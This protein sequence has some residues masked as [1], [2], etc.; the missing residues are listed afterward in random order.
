MGGI[1]RIKK[2]TETLVFVMGNEN[3]VSLSLSL[4]H[5][6]LTGIPH[7]F[8]FCLFP[9]PLNFSSFLQSQIAT[10]GRWYMWPS[11]SEQHQWSSSWGWALSV[12]VSA[13]ALDKWEKRDTPSTTVSERQICWAYLRHD[14]FLNLAE[15][16]QGGRGVAP[17][18]HHRS[19]AVTSLGVTSDKFCDKPETS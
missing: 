9:S 14:S 11:T 10:V 4:S 1:G 7:R 2:K 19:R 18:Y 15:A 3:L 6:C 17:Q 16:E 8:F 12:E 13:D 5:K